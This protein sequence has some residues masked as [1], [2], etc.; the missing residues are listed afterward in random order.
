MVVIGHQNTFNIGLMSSADGALPLLNLVRPI[1]IDCRKTSSVLISNT[2]S[3][4][5]GLPPYL[6]MFPIVVLSFFVL[7]FSVGDSTGSTVI[8]GGS[9]RSKCIVAFR[10]KLYSS[11]FLHRFITWPHHTRIVILYCTPV[12]S[13]D[14]PKMVNIPL[15]KLQLTCGAAVKICVLLSIG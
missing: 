12:V 15:P 2:I 9:S 11:S 3:A 5:V 14:I 10:T 8:F 4:P 6:G 1:I 13:P 7:Y